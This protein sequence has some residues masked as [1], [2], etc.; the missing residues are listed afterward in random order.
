M[1]QLANADLLTRRD[2]WPWLVENFPWKIQIARHWPFMGIDGGFLR[3]AR[4]TRFDETDLILN[5][6]AAVVRGKLKKG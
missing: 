2:L 1:A 3:V 4:T 6:I 5:T